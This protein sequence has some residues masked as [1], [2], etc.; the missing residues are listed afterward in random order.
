M[1]MMILLVSDDPMAILNLPQT[2]GVVSEILHRYRSVL[3]CSGRLH[4]QPLLGM[5]AL[6]L[7]EH[8]YESTRTTVLL[9][10]C[11]PH[12]LAQRN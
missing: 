6:L 2:H 5:L 1:F 4:W 11:R 10:C 9:S 12:A 8:R 3:R 7:K